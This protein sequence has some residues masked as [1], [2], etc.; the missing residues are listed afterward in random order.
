[1]MGS[2]FGNTK[3]AVHGLGKPGWHQ[4]LVYAV[5]GSDMTRCL[6]EAWHLSIRVPQH[7]Q[8]MD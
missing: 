5:S 8:V 7:M 4:W 2:L 3:G 1:M 6:A